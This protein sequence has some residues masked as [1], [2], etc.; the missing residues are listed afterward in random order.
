[1]NY[2]EE[3]IEKT[4]ELVADI[5]NIL[6]LRHM[7]ANQKISKIYELYDIFDPDYRIWDS[8]HRTKNGKVF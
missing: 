7:S 5:R 1:M 3:E 4:V 6:K 8:M 2:T